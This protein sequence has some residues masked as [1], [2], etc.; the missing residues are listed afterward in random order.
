MDQ[1][2]LNGTLQ[3]FYVEVV[4]RIS[5]GAGNQGPLK[6]TVIH[7]M[8]RPVINE[9]FIASSGEAAGCGDISTPNPH[10]PGRTPALQ[11]ELNGTKEQLPRT[12]KFES[13]NLKSPRARFCAYSVKAR[14]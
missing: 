14:E 8:R 1:Q 9:I 7:H 13:N 3:A 12:N 10:C 11:M 6:A 5:T 2:F 4:V